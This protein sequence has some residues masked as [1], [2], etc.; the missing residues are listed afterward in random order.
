MATG[1]VWNVIDW[2]VILQLHLSPTRDLT[3]LHF[4]CRI[5]MNFFCIMPLFTLFCF[6]FQLFYISQI[7]DMVTVVVFMY[8]F[9]QF[10]YRGYT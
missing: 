6:M 7:V 3:L 8:I 9:G 4:V 5:I 2:Q 1:K 10:E